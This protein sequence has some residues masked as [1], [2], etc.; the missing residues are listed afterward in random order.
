MRLVFTPHGWGDYTSWLSADRTNLTRINRLIDDALRDPT[1]GPSASPNRYATCS[2]EHGRG[3]S[4][5][6]TGS[7]TSST[8]K[9]WSSSKP[10]ST[11]RSTNSFRDQF[12]RVT[13]HSRSHGD[14]AAGKAVGGVR[15]RVTGPGRIG[16]GSLASRGKATPWRLTE[17][18]ALRRLT[19]PSGALLDRDGLP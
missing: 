6:S 13:A 10:A 8:A 11:A 1:S 5:R 7:A 19:A 18:R 2:P 16:Q 3:A 15:L 14:V 9:V 4:P 12:P 17:P